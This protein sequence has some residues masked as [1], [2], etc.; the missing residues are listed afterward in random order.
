MPIKKATSAA[1]AASRT[2]APQTTAKA[3][4]K[5]TQTR[6]SRRASGSVVPKQGK[7]FQ[8]LVGLNH[9]TDAPL[10]WHPRTPNELI[11]ALS[12]KEIQLAIQGST[13][14]SFNRNH[15]DI[16]V[17]MDHLAHIP[18]F[19]DGEQSLLL[20]GLDSAKSPLQTGRRIRFSA[21]RWIRAGYFLGA[22]SILCEHQNGGAL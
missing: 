11:Q 2:R 6:E 15:P 3:A 19:V 4:G 7:P 20:R 8:G 10:P 14:P 18:E 16:A 21:A 22:F 12:R 13:L 17:L 9:Q 5:H 1:P